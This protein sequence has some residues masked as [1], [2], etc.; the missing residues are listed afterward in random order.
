MINL[1]TPSSSHTA[2]HSLCV[3]YALNR[4]YRNQ[5]VD[6]YSHAI[7]I[8]IIITIITTIILNITLISTMRKRLPSKGNGGESLTCL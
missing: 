5:K 4:V 7:I 1:S 6:C 2:V 3:Q 8:I